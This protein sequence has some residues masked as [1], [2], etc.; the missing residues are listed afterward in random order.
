MLILAEL[1]VCCDMG[2]VGFACGIGLGFLVGLLVAASVVAPSAAV[3]SE[4]SDGG[5]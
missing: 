3:L 1:C 4:Q 5:T 2:F